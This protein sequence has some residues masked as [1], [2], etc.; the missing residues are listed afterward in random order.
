MDVSRSA[1][2]S[3]VAWGSFSSESAPTKAETKNLL[4]TTKTTPK[5]M[6]RRTRTNLKP[7]T[8]GTQINNL[9]DF[10]TFSNLCPLYKK[11]RRKNNPVIMCSVKRPTHE[12]S[13]KNCNFLFQ[14]RREP[15]TNPLKSCFPV[16]LEFTFFFILCLSFCF[17]LLL[18]I[19]VLFCCHYLR[20]LFLLFP[21]LVSPSFV[22]DSFT[23]PLSLIP[24]YPS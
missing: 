20:L 23:F 19:F 12:I 17:V 22:N 13:I 14:I 9:N 21:L 5:E 8:K 24:S 3:R 1:A 16:N 11:A 10:K 7:P 6:A 15:I 4:K 2:A 18:L